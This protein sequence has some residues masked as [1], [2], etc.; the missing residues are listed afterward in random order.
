MLENDDNDHYDN[1]YNNNDKSIKFN[2]S[3]FSCTIRSLP[4]GNF[5]SE[6]RSF[7]TT[8]MIKI[9]ITLTVF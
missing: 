8:V 4:W 7:S 1:T 5:L 6:I 2:V 9:I 3:Y